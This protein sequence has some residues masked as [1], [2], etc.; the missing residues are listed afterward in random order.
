MDHVLLKQVHGSQSV[1]VKLNQ[2]THFTGK[3]T[4]N[5]GGKTGFIYPSLSSII[6]ASRKSDLHHQIFVE[7]I[8]HYKCEGLELC[9]SVKPSENQSHSSECDK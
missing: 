5:T 8:S 3:L 9:K 6:T 2:G 1:K 4:A 7:E